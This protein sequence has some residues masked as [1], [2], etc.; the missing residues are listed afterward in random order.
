MIEKDKEPK[1]NKHS[2]HSNTSNCQPSPK[3]KEKNLK[4]LLNLDTFS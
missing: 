3:L 2:K 4:V 1:L